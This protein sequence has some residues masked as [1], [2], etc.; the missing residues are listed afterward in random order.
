MNTL[1]FLFAAAVADGLRGQL[2]E[3]KLIH[4]GPISKTKTVSFPHRSEP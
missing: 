4:M 2:A 3:R 1:Q